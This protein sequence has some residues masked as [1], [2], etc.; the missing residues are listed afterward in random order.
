MPIDGQRFLVTY[1]QVNEVQGFD[2]DTLADFLYT[3]DPIFV[4]VSEE[5]HENLGLHYHAYIEFPGRFYKNDVRTW[6]FHGK[7]PHWD[8][9]SRGKRSITK[10][11]EYIRKE[12]GPFSQR[13]DVPAIGETGRPTWFAVL[14][15][16]A[17][18]D[19]FMLACQTHFTKD[20][21]LRHDD[22]ERFAQGFF[23]KPSAYVDVHDPDSWI[24]PQAANDWVNS[25]FAE[26]CLC[27]R[28]RE[29]L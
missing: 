5:T 22:L 9:V 29:P 18:F 19:A 1:A 27:P 6:D 20:F 13:G 7:H 25:V 28:D 3:F 26:V 11:R 8:S 21:I 10:V 12:G 14:H 4:E 15:E 23:N 24:V 2:V 16:S 17:D